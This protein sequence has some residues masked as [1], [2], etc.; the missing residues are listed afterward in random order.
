MKKIVYAIVLCAMFLSMPMALAFP[1]PQSH[2]LLCSP[3][4]FS[5]GTFVGGVGKGHMAGG[6]FQIDTVYAYMQGVYSSFIVFIKFS[7]E[8]TNTDHVKI[9]TISAFV[10]QNI[11]IGNTNIQGQR[12]SLIAV[13][14]RKNH[15]Q[16]VGRIVGRPGPA[17]HI[18]GQFIPSI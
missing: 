12:T 17:S 8:L 6:S 2:S 3:L 18:W 4:A 7:G 5:D 9:G 16:F 1:P 15:D 14:M 13:L 11:V 10:V